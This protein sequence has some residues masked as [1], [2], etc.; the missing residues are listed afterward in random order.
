MRARRGPPT[1]GTMVDGSEGVR[2]Q[3][4]K[5]GGFEMKR[6][7]FVAAL[8]AAAVMTMCQSARAEEEFRFFRGDQRLIATSIA[9]GIGT[10]GGYY[11]LRHQHPNRSKRISK[12]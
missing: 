5:V 3:R 1:C 4:Q 10:T 6:V 8:L 12:A 7:V 2:I 11:A 9:V